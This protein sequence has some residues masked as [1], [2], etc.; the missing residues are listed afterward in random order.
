MVSTNR[1]I[2]KCYY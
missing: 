2:V 1:T